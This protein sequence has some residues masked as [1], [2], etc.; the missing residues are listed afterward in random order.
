MDIEA[1]ETVPIPGSEEERVLVSLRLDDGTLRA[2]TFPT[3]AAEWRI[4][5]Y[6]LDPDVDMDAV[7]EAL[8][9]EHTLPP[10]AEG[11]GLAHAP[12]I[13]T[14]RED[15]LGRVRAAKAEKPL[16]SKKTRGAATDVSEPMAKLKAACKVDARAVH[17]KRELVKDQRER[18]ARGRERAAQGKAAGPTR[19]EILENEVALMKAKKGEQGGDNH[20][21]ARAPKA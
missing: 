6:E 14:A 9:Y 10:A 2:V 7:L 15:W 17:L 21:A 20:D 4:A 1:V 5:E 3:D 16:T 19:V 11:K 18:L 8:V 13:A 12:D